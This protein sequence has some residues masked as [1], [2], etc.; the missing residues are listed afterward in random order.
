MIAAKANPDVSLEQNQKNML[1][2][3]EHEINHSICGLTN[4]GTMSF[5]DPIKNYFEQQLKSLKGEEL[6]NYLE[7]LQDEVYDFLFAVEGKGLV[8]YTERVSY[9]QM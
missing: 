6:E 2:T 4:T 8:Q 5:T 9:G 1:Q 3:A 7:K